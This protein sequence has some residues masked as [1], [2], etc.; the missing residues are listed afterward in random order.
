MMGEIYSRAQKVLVWLGRSNPLIAELLHDM[1]SLKIDENL[2]LIWKDMDDHCWVQREIGL[3]QLCKIEYWER[4]WVVQEYL[5]AK[6]VDMW[7]GTD[8][9]DPEKIK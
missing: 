8:S 5:L 7:C 2:K 1:H 6:S 4:L 9:V 3:A